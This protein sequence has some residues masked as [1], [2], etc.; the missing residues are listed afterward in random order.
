[1][2]L[3]VPW[4]TAATPRRTIN[5]PQRSVRPQITVAPLLIAALAFCGVL[6]GGAPDSHAAGTPWWNDCLDADTTATDWMAQLPDDLLISELSLP[7]THES[8][9]FYGPGIAPWCAICQRIG[10]DEQLKAGIRAFDI[11][12]RHHTDILKVMHGSVTLHANFDVGCWS[13]GI[14]NCGGILVGCVD[15]LQAHPGETILMRV[16]PNCGSNPDGS[17]YCDGNSVSFSERVEVDL[18]EH[19]PDYVYQWPVDDCEYMPNLGQVRG[20]IVVLQDFLGDY[21]LSDSFNGAALNSQKGRVSCVGDSGSVLTALSA[22]PYPSQYGEAVSF[23]VPG[24]ATLERSGSLSDAHQFTSVCTGDF[25]ANGHD[26]LAIPHFTCNSV[27]VFLFDSSGVI[28]SHSYGTVPQP[29]SAETADCDN[30]GDL[31]IV[32]TGWDSDYMYMLANNGDGTFAAA[33]P[34]WMGNHPYGL[35]IADLN[36]DEWPDYVTTHQS[37]N[38]ACD[39]Y[40][41][42]LL[43]PFFGGT[44]YLETNVGLDTYPEQVVADDFDD[45]GLDDAIVSFRDGYVN[46]Y[47]NT[48]TGM[49]YVGRITAGGDLRALEAADVDKD[50]D[51]D[52]IVAS[53]DPSAIHVYLNDGFFGFPTSYV[54]PVGANKPVGLSALDFDGDSD[55][56]LAVTEWPSSVWG[57]D[58][59]YV[60]GNQRGGEVWCP[61]KAYGPYWNYLCIQ[62]YF[63]IQGWGDLPHKADLIK[64]HLDWARESAAAHPESLFVNFLSGLDWQSPDPVCHIEPKEV[65][66]YTNGE[67]YVYLTDAL[68]AGEVWRCGLIM[69][70]FPGEGLIEATIGHN[71]FGAFDYVDA[72]LP[73]VKNSAVAWGDYD[74][75]GDLDIALAGDGG[76]GV[77]FVARVYRNDAG[78]FADIGAGLPG[79]SAGAA[80]WGDYDGDDDLDLVLTGDSGEYVARLYRNDGGSFNDAGAGLT[81][82]TNSAA[83]WGDYDN[84]DDLDLVLTGDSGSGY[85][86]SVYRNDGGNFNDAG[87]GLPG[88]AFGAVA[89]ADYDNDQDLDLALTGDSGSGYVATVYRNDSGNFADAGAGLPGVTRSAVAWGDYDNDGDPDLVLAGRAAAAYVTSVFR[90][91]A[92]NFTDV[93]AAIK[94]VGDGSVAWGDHDNDGD[95][96]LLLTGASWAVYSDT[97]YVSKVYRNDAGSFNRAYS[98]LVPVSTSSAA[99]GDYDGDGDLDIVLTGDGEGGA[100]IDYQA[101]LYRNGTVTTPSPHAAGTVPAQNELNVA[102]ST[103]ISVTFNVDMYAGCINDSTFVVNG[104]C[105][106]WYGGAISYDQPSKTAVFDPAVDFAVGEIVTVVL[107]GMRSSFGVPMKDYVWSFTTA[108]S[109]GS[110]AFP[111][112]VVYDV[113]DGPDALVSCEFDGNGDMDLAVTIQGA[114]TVAVLLNQGDGT[115]AAATTYP[116]GQAPSSVRAADLDGD[117]VVDLAVTNQAAATVSVLPGNGNGTFSSGATYA[118]GSEPRSVFAADLNADGKLDL[119]T[120]NWAGDVSVLL[121]QGDGTFATAV[122]YAAGAHAR[123]VFGGDLDGD[124]D[125]DLAVAN[126]SSDNVSILLNG[127]DG[128]FAPQVIYAVGDAPL[129][130]FGADLD[131]DGDVDL[132]TANYWSDDVTVLTNAGNATFTA[133]AAPVADGPHAVFASDL[134]GDGDLDLTTS[135]V[136]SHNISVL[137]NHGDG[138]FAPQM[139]YPAGSEPMAVFAADLDGDGDLDLAT[140]NFDSDNISVLMNNEA[141]GVQLVDTNLI[142][143][144]YALH[145]SAPNPSRTV[146]K[147][148]LDL[149]LAGRVRLEVYNVSGRCVRTLVNEHMDPGRYSLIWDGRNSSGQVVADGV[150]FVRVM[151][152]S[153]TATQKLVRLR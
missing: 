91:D 140:A 104:M 141:V 48:G 98:W 25:D 64:Q 1:M 10:F 124:G 131:G 85:V 137:L 107:T 46:L 40:V 92:G 83:A 73:G 150:Y 39:D 86:A 121:N 63:N 12:L 68:N 103:D 100:S 152:G 143:I 33:A 69:A 108:T 47:H 3:P 138:T 58:R 54:I 55:I 82:V 96:D 19:A 120:A 118:T 65:A 145:R 105:S 75:D 99:W 30:D 72:G 146:T 28:Y 61:G 144:H 87:V 52:V 149:P 122:S 79:V 43:G 44:F 66:Y 11:R 16:A 78:I 60:L 130:V 50:G 56:D 132:T 136:I 59:I 36:G 42:A 134:D 5:H 9:G 76:D 119:A 117:G 17:F 135:Q 57:L 94:N 116:V 113:G 90:N 34:S 49:S 35:A 4:S 153:F 112:Q 37:P 84:D 7:G 21:H 70:D 111:E 26:D 129:S 81:G 133:Q 24:D 20:K 80:V 115:F 88:V 125:I 31:D 139:T 77:G 27:G 6:H 62:D 142:P 2:K 22:Y 29:I 8:H 128:T 14:C 71:R 15:F 74:A 18:Q 67:T 147:I 53:V 101:V 151:A 13:P 51:P 32:T 110:G 23:F 45:D 38:V 89:W 148:G 123:S 41:K 97:L 109:G 102:V 127:G 95:L 126:E 114:N 93:G 106:G